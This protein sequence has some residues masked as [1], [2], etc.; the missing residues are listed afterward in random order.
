MIINSEH[1][2]LETKKDEFL[3]SKPFPHLQLKNF[4]KNDF[5]DDFQNTNEE[6]KAKESGINFDTDVEDKKWISKNSELSSVTKKIIDELSS[7]S[8]ANNL[9]NLTG[10]RDLF[11]TTVG[12]T[13]LAN[14]HEM[15]PGG[16]LAPHVDHSSEP[17][18][19][20]PHVL[21][22]VVYL[23]KECDSIWGGGTDLLNSNGSKIITKLPYIPNSAVIF[24]H[25]PFSL[26]CVSRIDDN[27]KFLI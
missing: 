8:W 21:N 17:K 23:T 16:L 12:N 24:L 9:R 20:Y 15:K 11:C 25:T 1:Y 3:N 10:I 22:I 26:H 4:L 13:D 2:N 27:S 5:F 6:T 18:T 19:G 7:D 14:Y